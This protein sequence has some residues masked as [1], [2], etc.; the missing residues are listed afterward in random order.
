[1]KRLR[2]GVVVFLAGAA[3]ATT[4]MLAMGTGQ[5]IATPPAPADALR[6]FEMPAG[7]NV[8][9]LAPDGYAWVVAPDGVPVYVGMR[10]DK[11]GPGIRINLLNPKLS[12]PIAGKSTSHT[13]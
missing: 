8:F 7:G 10:S 13:P 11:S 9:V 1:M 2:T 5:P 12:E 3:C 6:V 4:L